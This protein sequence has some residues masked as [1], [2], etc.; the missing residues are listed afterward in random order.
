MILWIRS[1]LVPVYQKKYVTEKQ[2]DPEPSWALN[3]ICASLWKG[4]LDEKEMMRSFTDFLSLRSQ[5]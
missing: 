1:Y 4:Y 5:S 2:G 3:D